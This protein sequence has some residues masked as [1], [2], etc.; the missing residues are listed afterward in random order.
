MKAKGI[1]KAL[2]GASDFTPLEIL[3]PNLRSS[4]QFLANSSVAKSRND[5]KKVD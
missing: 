2:D 5:I 3:C 4:A 1:E